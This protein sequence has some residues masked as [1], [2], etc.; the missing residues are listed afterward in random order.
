L[1]YERTLFEPIPK[2]ERLPESEDF[3][4]FPM[5]IAGE[6]KGRER[7]VTAA[8][9][10]RPMSPRAFHEWWERVVGHSNVA[11]RK[12]HTTRHTYAPAA[13]EASDGDVYGVK[14]ALGHSSVRT[15]E[16]YLHAGMK[17]KES[18]AR[19]LAAARRQSREDRQP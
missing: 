12:P 4:W 2:L 18:V 17:A 5:R 3:F 10:E 13:L 1:A 11:Y 9:P 15:T 7:Q 16:L 19:K 6:Y 8:Y 14:E